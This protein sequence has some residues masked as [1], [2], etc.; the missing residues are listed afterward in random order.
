MKTIVFWI[1]ITV[2]ILGSV[3]DIISCISS[4]NSAAIQQK[5]TSWCWAAS[6]DYLYAEFN[7]S[8]YTQEL[9]AKRFCNRYCMGEDFAPCEECRWCEKVFDP[10]NS[11]CGNHYY[12]LFSIMYYLQ[13]E[14][15]SPTSDLGYFV[16]EDAQATGYHGLADIICL[17]PRVFLLAGMAYDLPTGTYAHMVVVYGMDTDG[18]LY[19][20]VHFMDP[21]DG[22]KKSTLAHSFIN[23]G[24]A[25]ETLDWGAWTYFIGVNGYLGPLVGIE[26][27][28]SFGAQSDGTNVDLSFEIDPSAP[29]DELAG[30]YVSDNPVGPA[31]L[32]ENLV[33]IPFLGQV[34]EWT[35]SYRL[36]YADE[37]YY[38]LNHDSYCDGAM[39]PEE[40]YAAP[41][42][43]ELINGSQ[44]PSMLA[45]TNIQA[46]DNTIDRGNEAYVSWTLSAD[47]NKIDCYNVYTKSYRPGDNPH[48]YPWKW[49][50]SVPAGTNFILDTEVSS[51]I[52]TLYMVS[53]AHHGD[54]PT[55]PGDGNYGIWN[56]FSEVSQP[57]QSVD[58]LENLDLALVSNDTLFT[59]PASDEDT[60]SIVL[61]ITGSDGLP[62]MG[63]PAD[64]ILLF[65]L[66]RDT[67]YTC[68]G[69]TVNPGSSTNSLG[70]VTFNIPDI[71][72]VGDVK[73]YA[74][75]HGTFCRSDTVYVVI[76]SPDIRLDEYK[77]VDILD[78]A[79][80]SVCYPCYC[81]NQGFNYLY[82]YNGD[83]SV[84][85]VDF[86]LFSR[87]W[88][89]SC[90]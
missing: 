34:N 55:Q 29:S 42:N 61:T 25:G 20:Q 35:D 21:F 24:T 62:T 85:L 1:V 16:I 80:F 3:S 11:L 33:D 8:A 17:F 40:L 13:T 7:A 28:L 68:E 49:K 63:V 19:D 23:Y 75:I 30:V 26:H 47:D 50:K 45:P 5:S 56:D 83:C 46:V 67:V 27:I 48:S 57:F 31:R 39:D 58:E 15:F 52:F 81:G 36:Q 64:D 2:V 73:I 88:L 84:D 70:Q 90:Q 76:K 43:P 59:C 22:E 12:S 89:H 14:N 4:S 10:P 74:G 9:I 82:D 71:G 32:I 6:V 69:D 54:L 38:Y 51:N 72:G 41:G 18:Y 77:V 60:L 37:Y 86:S 66:A 53:S 44:R 65:F 87:N 78:L 79:E